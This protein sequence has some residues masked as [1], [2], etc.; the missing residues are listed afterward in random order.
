MDDIAKALYTDLKESNEAPSFVDDAAP[1]EDSNTKLGLEIVKYVIGV[2]KA[3]RAE[4]AAAAEKAATRQKIM[5]L[6]DQKKDEA[7]GAKSTEEL[8]ALLKTL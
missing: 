1:S 4:A 6:I 8:E 7:L 2:K 5:S 3:Q